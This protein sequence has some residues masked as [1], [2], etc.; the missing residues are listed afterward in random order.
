[1]RHFQTQNLKISSYVATMKRAKQPFFKPRLLRDLRIFA[2]KLFRL[3][4]RLAMCL[5]GA[6]RLVLLPR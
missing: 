3:R 1:M 4:Q 5:L 6:W 2:V